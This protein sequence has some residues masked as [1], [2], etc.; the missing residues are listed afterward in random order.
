MRRGT[1]RS[2]P[3]ARRGVSQ[4]ED[5]KTS[6]LGTTY[7][8]GNGL[9]KGVWSDVDSALGNGRSSTMMAWL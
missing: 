4:R 8:F 1:D 7:D 5:L 3:L 2:L 9:S 6:T